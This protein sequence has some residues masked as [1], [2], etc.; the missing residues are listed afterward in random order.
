MGMLS[1]ILKIKAQKAASYFKKQPQRVD[2]NWPLGIRIGGTVR[3]DPSTFIVAGDSL[4]MDEP[5]GDCVVAA[6]GWYDCGGI[7]YHRFYLNDIEGNEFILEVGLGR[8]GGVGELMLYQA[9]DEIY[10]ETTEDWDL[11]LNEENGLIGFKDFS[12]PDEIVYERLWGQNGADYM[13]P[14][15]F[16]EIVTDDPF[17][18]EVAKVSHAAML[19]GRTLDESVVEYLWV[20]NTN[21]DH[22]AAVL[23]STG[24]EIHP[25]SLTVL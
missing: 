24:V 21:D 8:S 16:D 23:V 14:P 2:L 10:P 11:W 18:A 17:V 9:A 5:K 4:K 13:A 3:L 25:A 6:A 22:G 12:T 20:D 19:Y 1:R 7:R 15:E